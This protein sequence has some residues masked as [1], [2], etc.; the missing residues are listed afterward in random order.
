MRKSMLMIGVL[1]AMAA[2]G[3]AAAAPS[4]A[5]LRA[6]V[7]SGD[8]G[9]L[10]LAMPNGSVRAIHGKIA[11]GTRVSLGGGRLVAIGRAHRAVFRGVVLRRIG[12]LTFLTAARHLVIVRTQRAVASARDVR[13]PTGSVV[14]S[15]VVIDDH[16]DLDEQNEEAIGHERKI[17]VQAVVA[18]VAAGSITLNVNGQA[19]TIPL[20]AGLTL[21]ATVV[22]TQVTVEVQFPEQEDVAPAAT[23]TTMTTTTTTAVVTTNRDGGDRHGGDDGDGGHHG[24]DGHD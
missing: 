1:C 11:V 8:H 19:L 15:T 20:P 16:G 22:G 10:L 13:P 7:I 6:T 21:P 12:N 24:G 23:T 2:G 18:S 5:S 14:Q 9:T 17:E 4:P 3:S